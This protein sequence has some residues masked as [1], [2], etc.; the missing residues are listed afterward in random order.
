[1]KRRISLW[2]VAGL[3]VASGWAV[4][5][6]ETGPWSP[7]E[8]IWKIVDITCPAALLRTFPLNVYWFIL[9][10][11]L[12]YGVFG[13]GIELLRRKPVARVSN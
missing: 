13:A 2:A 10:N 4:A 11:V 3:I 5:G 6:L 12:T 9:L 1:M 8:P 7:S